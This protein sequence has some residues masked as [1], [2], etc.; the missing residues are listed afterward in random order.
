MKKRQ[1]KSAKNIQLFFDFFLLLWL[2]FSF[3]MIILEPC[4][5]KLNCNGI[6]NWC[7]GYGKNSNECTS[8]MNRSNWMVI[9]EEDEEE[10]RKIEWDYELPSIALMKIQ[11]F[12]S[13][14][15][16]IT[17][18]RRRM[19]KRHVLKSTPTSSQPM[20]SF[21]K[22]ITMPLIALIIITISWSW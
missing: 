19:L 8:S 20:K 21:F 2:L 6:E 12:L 11:K 5:L 1:K 3:S 16:L 10:K 4:K 14:T 22:E 13:A 17:N 18:D 7:W 9:N 15:G